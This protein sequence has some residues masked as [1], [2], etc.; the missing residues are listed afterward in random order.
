M[1][2]GHRSTKHPRSLSQSPESSKEIKP[3][4]ELGL[5]PYRGWA[6]GLW[7]SCTAS[8][9]RTT[10]LI[11]ELM[12]AAQYQSPIHL[13]SDVC[14]SWFSRRIHGSGCVLRTSTTSELS[15]L[16]R[17]SLISNSSP[18]GREVEIPAHGVLSVV[19]CAPPSDVLRDEVASGEWRVPGCGRLDRQE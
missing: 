17:T 14:P 19:G 15:I 13:S 16:V 1:W 10:K 2:Y 12:A 11:V 8:L 3:S 9:F 4:Q 5:E 6:Q 7:V 18:T